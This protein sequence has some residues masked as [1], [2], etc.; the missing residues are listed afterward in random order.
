[1]VCQHIDRNGLYWDISSF[2][3]ALPPDVIEDILSH[4]VPLDPG[5]DKI[6]W[7]WDPSG[8]FSINV[9]YKKLSKGV[10][11]SHLCKSLTVASPRD[12]FSHEFSY[13]P[14]LYKGSV[15]ALD[16]GIC[17]LKQQVPPPVGYVKLNINGLAKGNRGR[18]G[19]GGVI[20]NHRGEF[21]VSYAGYI[22]RQSNNTVKLWAIRQGIQLCINLKPVTVNI[23]T[24]S[25]FA[26]SCLHRMI[27]GPAEHIILCTNIL[28]LLTK[29][30]SS[31]I[32][33]CYRELNGSADCMANYGASLVSSF[34]GSLQPFHNSA[35]P[36]AVQSLQ[37]EG[38]FEGSNKFSK[39]RM[40]QY[41]QIGEVLGSLKALM[42]LK[43]EIPINQRQCSLLFDMLELAFDTISEEIRQNLRLEDRNTK[44]K[45]LEL[46]MKELHRIF[47]EADLYI[48]YCMDMKDWWGKAISLHMN[49]DCVELHIHNL[50]CCFPVVIEAIETA[51]EIS[52]VDEEDMQRRRIAL[53]RKYNEEYDD[54]KLFQWKFG[55]QYLVA[56]EICSRFETAWREDRWL[57]LEKIVDKTVVASSKQEQ[58]LVELLLRKLND[59]DTSKEKLLPSNVLVGAQDYYVKRR[60]G[61]SSSGP[62]GGGR[63]KEI[64]WLG[65][66][67]AL[68]TFYGDIGPL[69]NEISLILSLSHPNVLQYLCALYD[70]DRKEG[71]LVMELMSKDLG[72][73]IKE[74]SGQRKRI[75]FSLPVAVDVMLQIARGM[76]YLHSKKI[77]HGDLHPSKILL[78][79]RSA[80]NGGL[81][82][83]KVAGFGL[84]SIK[85]YG[86]KSPNPKP[87]EDHLDIWLA[88]EVMADLEHSGSKSTAKY[89]EKADVYSFG[90]LC[91]EL[92]TGK[93]PFEDGHLQGE[94]MVRNIRAGERPLFSYP[95]PKYLANLTK[96]CW[97][98][99]P[100]QRPSFLSICRILRYI[101][102][103]LVIDPDHGHPDSP[104]P[105]VDYCDM[106]AGYL[107][108]FPP[109]EGTGDVGPVSQIPFQI[110][111]YKLVE[112]DKISNKNWDLGDEGFAKVHRPA[113]MFDDDE[114]LAA[115]DD[116]FLAPS[117][118]RSVCSEIIGGRKN[119]AVDLRS[120]ISEIPH[121]KLFSFDQRS[122]GSESPGK[123]FLSISGG[124]R[125]PV[126]GETPERKMDQRSPIIQ[127]GKKKADQ[128]Q[129]PKLEAADKAIVASKVA[130]SQS[131]SHE[132]SNKNPLTKVTGQ[133]SENTEVLET[134]Q[135]PRR[136]VDQKPASS[137]FSEGKISSRA[138]GHQKLAEIPEKKT[139]KNAELIQT[140]DPVST[141]DSD[142]KNE[143]TPKKIQKSGNSE[144]SEKKP[145][146]I[147]KLIDTKN[148]NFP[149]T[150]NNDSPK[151]SPARMKK[152]N[153]IHSP[154]SSS[155]RTKKSNPVQS[156]ALSP[157]RVKKTKSCQSPASSP[158]RMKKVNASDSPASSPSRIFYTCGSPKRTP[159]CEYP[160]PISSPLNPCARCS[161][162]G[163]QSS[164][165]PGMSPLRPRMSHVPDSGSTM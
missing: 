84:S 143:S 124:D 116:L 145:M 122:F 25:R 139:L 7:G 19:M 91:F 68:R 10:Y 153:P 88:P 81:F 110:F 77:Y 97:Q 60:L 150:S 147:R 15:P 66:S 57:L 160:S 118:R 2:P 129:K 117:D 9:A 5:P 78:K 14:V 51:A 47:K 137:E 80:S 70:E 52:G 46:P 27:Q 155:A 61:C 149:E 158:A 41:R 98:T 26:I 50:L 108:K 55:K 163:K 16:G 157:A 128:H 6:I 123:R 109:G 28:K 23:E 74:N 69:N 115:M 54:P 39:T 96:K 67:F 58:R 83:A 119:M 135:S 131:P 103:I 148:K 85:S 42:V 144:K 33:A 38:F 156:P 43:H 75:P 120:V 138:T 121:R 12:R 102:K 159:A 35:V 99:N 59:M 95:S 164:E 93:V 24:D 162:L 112:K 32:V 142:K 113:S 82:Q 136:V 165:P 151:S 146:L 101:K 64:H 21:L 86:P 62:L 104:P 63:F 17:C 31:S 18:V 11:V 132:N 111:A 105:L 56:R 87:N 94:K 4:P 20:R 37:T 100:S 1:M 133:K 40:E 72:T 130:E 161:R 30:R 3:A 71:F 90:M 152:T 48:K 8:K 79:P 92:L 73:Y 141:K 29:L 49:K 36:I 89:S 140:T 44:W 13:H 107:K 134:K 34:H 22:G 127:A 114:H 53:M 126:G 106:E 65:E 154:A 45:P 125:P 76:E